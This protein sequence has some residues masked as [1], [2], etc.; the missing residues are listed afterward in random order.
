[1]Y[2]HNLSYFIGNDVTD[3]LQPTVYPNTNKQAC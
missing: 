1:M 2:Q 3:P